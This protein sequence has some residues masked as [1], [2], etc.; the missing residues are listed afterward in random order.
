MPH[1]TKISP[2]KGGRKWGSSHASGA[3]LAWALPPWLKTQL[4]PCWLLSSDSSF[5][6]KWEKPFCKMTREVSGSNSIG[7][8][9]FQLDS[10]SCLVSFPSMASV[11]LEPL[12][13]LVKWQ[14]RMCC[15]SS[16]LKVCSNMEIL[17]QS[18]YKHIKMFLL[19]LQE[20]WNK[21]VCSGQT[22]TTLG[23]S[24]MGA[25]VLSQVL[26]PAST[27]WG[28]ILMQLPGELFKSIF[29]CK[30]P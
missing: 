30:F 11:F 26:C 2:P 9:G 5:C 12:R 23:L 8:W 16:P 6:F 22:Q 7:S 17:N 21:R 13:D 25:A 29:C 24:Q 10:C 15:I 3:G 20:P 19:G 18:G 4:V 1:L 14:C 27:V 28:F